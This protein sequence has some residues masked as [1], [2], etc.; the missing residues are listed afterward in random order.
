MQSSNNAAEQVQGQLDI[1]ENSEN[2]LVIIIIGTLIRL[3]YLKMQKQALTNSVLCP[4]NN[5]RSNSNDFCIQLVSSLLILYGLFGFYNQS[6][7]IAR[8]SC[9]AGT[10]TNNQCLEIKL[11]GI[12]IAVS[13]VRLYQLL[14][15]N[16]QNN[17]ALA[18][19]NELQLEE[20]VA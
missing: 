10:I 7:D 17:V 9:R 16:N 1:L 2:L 4:E 19:Q 5:Q 11:G 13:L 15:S 3:G 12:I 20:T 14:E 6:K 8:E 18:N